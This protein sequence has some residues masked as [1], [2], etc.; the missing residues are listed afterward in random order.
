M[1]AMER[2]SDIICMNCYAPMLV[3]VNPGG[4]QWRPDLIGYNA[5]NSFGSPSYYAIQLF[6]QHLGDVVLK[7]SLNGLPPTGIAP[8]DYSVTKDTAAG[9]IHVKVV[10]LTEGPQLVRLTLNG[11]SSVAKKAVVVTLSGSPEESNSIQDPAHLVPVVSKISGVKPSFD[12]VF[13][14]YSITVL[15]LRVR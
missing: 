6:S 12:H 10:N 13:G 3:N 15:E 11:V 4:R 7:A 14:P 2:N 1:A 8:L 9:V 5:L